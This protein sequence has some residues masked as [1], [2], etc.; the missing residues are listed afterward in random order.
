[1]NFDVDISRIDCISNENYFSNFNV[2]NTSQSLE[3]PSQ[4]FSARKTLSSSSTPM[5]LV[6]KNKDILLPSI[7]LIIHS[8][9]HVYHL[10]G[11]L[12]KI[13]NKKRYDTTLCHIN[14]LE[15]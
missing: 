13:V 11:G 8:L 15:G 4:L 10:T 3:T 7:Q 14:T 1:M 6:Y 9:T 2:K 12:L 5:N